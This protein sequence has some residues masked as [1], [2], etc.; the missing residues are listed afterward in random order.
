ML[1]LSE[2]SGKTAFFRK[3]RDGWL[4]S[5]LMPLAM[6]LGYLLATKM[7][8]GIGLFAGLI[9][10]AIL[11]TCML[12]VETG[13]YINIAYSFFVCHFSRQF[14]NYDIP[15]GI[16]SNVLIIAT[17]LGLFGKKY[18]VRKDYYQFVK[19]PVIVLFLI[20]MAYLGIELFNPLMHS[21]DGWFTTI[22]ALVTSALLLFLAYCVFDNYA[23]IRRFIIIVFVFSALV[24]LY[25]CIQQWHGLF[26]YELWWVSADPVRFGLIFIGGDFRKFSTMGDPTGFAI[27]M[28][29]CAAFF[30]VL[31]TGK[32]S[33]RKRLLLLAGIVVMVL[34]MAYSGTR[35]GNAMLLG[36][37]LMFIM[38][39][40]QKAGTRLFLVLGGLVFLAVM[41]GPFSGNA[42][43]YRFR[44][45]FSGSKDESFNVRE[46]NRRYIQPYIYRHPIGGGLG[47]TGAYGAAV[48]PGHELAGFPTDSG[49]L[50]KALE[51]GWIGLLLVI[52]LYYTV[53]RAGIRGY[54]QCTNERVR[55]IYAGATACMFSFYVAEFAQDSIGQITD[56]V[57]YY[58]MIAI[59]LRLKDFDKGINNST[60]PET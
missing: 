36:G 54:F 43:I 1:P 45:T 35:T 28:S 17:F 29:S 30:I 37:I 11:I 22:R 60:T 53:I 41:F 18:N 32:W 19:S 38:L 34:G 47:T 31:L 5:M 15:V 51:T 40:I 10:L 44:S 3:G 13:L 12:S 16:G 39:T 55:L 42:T 7:V 56:M 23:S 20:N 26:D 4:L 21:F 49:Y 50:R 52:A 9:G 46:L 48:N 57:V 25:G 33:F 58:P 27:V 59:I 2:K 6:L 14:F 8:V 24:G